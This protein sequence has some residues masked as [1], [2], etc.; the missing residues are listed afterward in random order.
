MNKV[1]I[2]ARLEESYDAF[3]QYTHQ[4]SKDEYEYAPEGKWNA[5]EQ[6]L[7]LIKSVKPVAKGLG[8]PK[9]LIKYN[10]GKA[11]RP[12]RDFDGLVERYKRGL[13]ENP[14]IAPKNYA[15]SKVKHEQAA[16]LN[17]KLKSYI[18]V[19]NTKLAKWNEEQLDT[20][21]APHPLIGKLTFREVLYFT[22]YHAQ[23]HQLQI[24]RY[25]KGV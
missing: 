24:K 11:N 7:H 13:A 22:I 5:G 1:E 23:H 8:M 3:I 2:K 21:V 9:F 25:L 10:F 12:S 15:P 4:L 16:E 17:K 6:T 18:E 19:I 14:G 20:Y